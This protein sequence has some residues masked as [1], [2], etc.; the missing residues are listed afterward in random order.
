MSIVFTV[1]VKVKVNKMGS[2]SVCSTA[3]ENFQEVL[4]QYAVKGFRVIGL[5]TKSLSAKLTWHQAQRITRYGQELTC[6]IH[7]LV[8][9]TLVRCYVWG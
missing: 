3:P 5:A 1:N 7:A 2:L 4:H 6:Y 9:H 8:R